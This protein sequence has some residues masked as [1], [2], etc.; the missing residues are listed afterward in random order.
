[1]LGKGSF[2]ERLLSGAWQRKA[3]VTFA[4]GKEQTNFF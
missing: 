3:E 4:L 1:M 2:A